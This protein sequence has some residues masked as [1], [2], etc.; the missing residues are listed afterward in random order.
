MRLQDFVSQ[1]GR[2][3]IS[4]ADAAQQPELVKQMQVRLKDLG[5]YLGQVDGLWGPQTEAAIAEF[6]KALNL[7]NAQTKLLGS[8]FAKRLIE[9]KEVSRGQ[10][11]TKAQAEY[12]FGNPIHFN[13]LKD[14]NDCLSRFEINTLPRMRH[15][16]SQIAHES[17]G[18][19]WLKEL[20]SGWDYEW[21]S[22]LGNTQPGD[23]PRYKGAGAIQLTGRANY[24]AFANYMN[25]PRIMEG[26]DY[27][28]SRYPF[29]SAG[30]WW[31]NNSMNALCDR[32]ATVEQVT[33]RVNGGYNGLDDRIYY[34]QRAA[35]VI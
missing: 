32:G 22:D 25:D 9:T 19:R 1:P 31:R 27:V 7:N 17:G 6:C 34:Y 18:L 5:L 11:I 20:A 21:R 15:F 28:A 23:G 2:K 35:Q 24:Q 16:M 30:F 8:T 13:E 12:V 3:V 26:V 29:T 4:F 10:L 14:L 33:R